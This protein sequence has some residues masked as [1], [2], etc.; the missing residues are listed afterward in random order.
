MT[1]MF[2]QCSRICFRSSACV[3]DTRRVDEGRDYKIQT[4]CRS[5]THLRTMCGKICS[6]M[7][8]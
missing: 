7:S 1:F 4:S 2:G 5:G 6:E 3:Y 8:K